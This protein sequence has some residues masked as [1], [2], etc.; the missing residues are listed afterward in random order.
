MGTRKKTGDGNGHGPERIAPPLADL[1]VP[2][3][4]LAP[5]PENARRHPQR[6]LDA[7]R[8]SLD[9][10]GQQAPVVYAIQGRRKVVVK[11]NGILAAAAALGW[12]RLAAIRSDL[13]DRAV[14]A[15]AIADN[16]TGELSEWDDALLAEQL[17]ELEEADFHL[18]D[19]GFT[20]DEMAELVAGLDEHGGGQGDVEEDEP[21]EPEKK[22]ISRTGE[23]WLLGDHRLLCGDATKGDHVA[24]A[25]GGHKPML[26]VTDPPYGIEYDPDW[27]N[28]AFRAN[29]KPNGG[30]AVGKVSND[31]RADWGDAW[32]LFVGDV[33]YVWHAA[34]PNEAMFLASL[35]AAGFEARNHIIWAKQQLV[36][37]RGHYHIQ[38]EP[39]WYAVRKGGTAHWIGGRKQTTLW[40]IDKPH[41]S[42]TGHSAQKPVECMARPIRNHGSEHVYDPFCGS[43]TTIIACEHLN[44]KCCAIEI[45][46]RYV[47]VAVR[48]WQ[49]FTGRQATL[50]GDGRTFGEIEAERES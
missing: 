19:A 45:E 23:L 43:G 8:A 3:S 27:R 41:K 38:H 44:R 25:L 18:G 20:D 32:A 10:F 6:N 33:A 30:R 24:A 2:I 31:D 1:A 14:R 40:R 17:R 9:R 48:R 47:D 16:R 15:Y 29:G 5:D 13:R 42:E 39:C 35:E 7:I 26:M 28:K 4:Q 49:N 36:I 12:K 37:G 50:D 22:A 46:P 34:G 11:G 21:P